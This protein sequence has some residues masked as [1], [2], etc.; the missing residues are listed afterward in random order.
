VRLAQFLHQQGWTHL[1]GGVTGCSITLENLINSSHLMACGEP[2]DP[3][4]FGS[5]LKAELLTAE[6]L[7]RVGQGFGRG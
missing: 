4:P 3:E 7:S 2:F 6:G 5:E 1:L